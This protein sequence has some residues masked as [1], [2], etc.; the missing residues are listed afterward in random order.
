M[1]IK[2]VHHSYIT[3]D[4]IREK[5]EFVVIGMRCRPSA[6]LGDSVASAL[7]SRHCRVC[8]FC[9]LGYEQNGF[10]KVMAQ[11]KTT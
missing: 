7:L 1:C 11:S 8:F 9:S 6:V 10:L 4:R 5:G 3:V 2:I